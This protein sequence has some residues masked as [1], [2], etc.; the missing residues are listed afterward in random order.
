MAKG[1]SP[2]TGVLA[3]VFVIGTVVYALAAQMT[4][5]ALEPARTFMRWQALWGNGTYGVKYTF[6]VTWFWLFCVPLAPLSLV[7]SLAGALAKKQDRPAMPEW[8][9]IEWSRLREP[10]RGLL[11]VGLTAVGFSFAGA[12]LVDPRMFAPVGFLAKIALILAPFALLT[13][14]LVALDV[15]MPAR[16]VVG[17]A[18]AVE[19]EPGATPEQPASHVLR[20]GGERFVL[21]EALWRELAPG[22]EIAVRST[23]IFNRVIELARRGPPVA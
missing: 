2:V 21:P 6:A 8:P 20:V 1:S 7:S 3:V 15:A 13:G 16:V 17:V 22:D 18:D 4:T 5:P 9:R 11:G 19:R 14:P 10:G 12:C 23:A